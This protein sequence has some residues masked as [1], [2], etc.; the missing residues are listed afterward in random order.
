MFF[1]RINASLL[2]VDPFILYYGGYRYNQPNHLYF[3]LMN[4][5]ATAY[6]VFDSILEVS[7]GTDDMLTNCHH[8]CAILVSYF[9]MRANHSG[10]EY[11][12]ILTK[13]HVSFSAATLGRG[14]EPLPDPEDLPQTSQEDRLDSVQGE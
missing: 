7:Y 5:H 4:S 2:I 11:I 14:V 3:T 12:G 9:G 1:S 10:F 8:V 6:F 13:S